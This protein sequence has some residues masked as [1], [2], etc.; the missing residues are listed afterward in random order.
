MGSSIGDYDGDGHLDIAKTNFLSDD[1][2]TL[3]PP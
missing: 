1:T 3:Y 2:A